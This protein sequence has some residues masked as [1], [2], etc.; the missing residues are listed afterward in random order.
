VKQIEENPDY[1]PWSIR[2]TAVYQKYE[3]NTGRIT[4]VL[5]SPSD[6]AKSCLEKAIIQVKE[7]GQ[8]LN[9]FDLHR[10]LISTLHGNWRLYIRGLEHSL[11]DQVC[12]SILGWLGV[13]LTNK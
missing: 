5:I 7:R 9:A 11:R 6:P 13:E 1:N 3:S 2:D 12:A 4:F 8:L 10:V